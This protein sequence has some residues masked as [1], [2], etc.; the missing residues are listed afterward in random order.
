MTC[1][2]GVLC[3]GELADNCSSYSGVHMGEPAIVLKTYK[4]NDRLSLSHEPAIV[5]ELLRL[6]S[7]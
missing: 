2:T 1:T 3:E 4:K 6:S 7:S 5:F